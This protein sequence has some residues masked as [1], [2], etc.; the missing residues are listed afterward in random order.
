MMEFVETLVLSF[1]V[2]KDKTQIATITFA[3]DAQVRFDL[4][5]YADS[6][7]VVDAMMSMR[8]QSGGTNTGQA[9]Q[10]LREQTFLTSRGAR[11]GILKV[12]I[13]VTDGKSRNTDDT[14][15]QAAKARALGYVLYA[16]GV[17]TNLDLAELQ[18]IAGLQY[19]DRFYSAETFDA[20]V[21]LNDKIIRSTCDCEYSCL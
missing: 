13:V 18:G 14:L 15:R 2:G 1:D 12:G 17:G 20:L 4:N 10:F 11:P 8:R 19:P 5:R 9:L 21:S 3:N 7:D 6:L 16:V